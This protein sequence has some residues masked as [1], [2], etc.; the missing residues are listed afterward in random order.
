MRGEAYSR[1]TIGRM[2]FLPSI[3][4][5]IFQKNF[6]AHE[7]IKILFYIVDERKSNFL[8]YNFVNLVSLRKHELVQFVCILFDFNFFFV[9]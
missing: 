5:F 8:L 6:S 2:N 3:F 1:D 4:V 7:S 9:S